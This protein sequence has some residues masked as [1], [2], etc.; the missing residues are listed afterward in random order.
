MIQQRGNALIACIGNFHDQ[1]GGSFCTS[2]SIKHKQYSFTHLTPAAVGSEERSAHNC[3]L[4]CHHMAHGSSCWG[5]KVATGD[6]RRQ[7]S[8]APF[9]QGCFSKGE[10]MQ[11]E[12]SWSYGNMLIPSG[13][14]CKETL[15]IEAASSC[16]LMQNNLDKKR[17]KPLRLHLIRGS[18]CPLNVMK[19]DLVMRFSWCVSVECV[20]WKRCWKKYF[21]IRWLSTLCW[22]VRNVCVFQLF[23]YFVIQSTN[24]WSVGRKIGECHSL[25]LFP[26]SPKTHKAPGLIFSFGFFTNLPKHTLQKQSWPLEVDFI[27]CF[28]KLLGWQNIGKD[29]MYSI[30]ATVFQLKL[31]P[32]SAFIPL[33]FSLWLAPSLT[34]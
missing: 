14:E 17:T 20:F 29:L 4:C 24:I 15:L 1:W 26:L 6:R 27:Y 9:N 3:F 33:T 28:L 2:E 18:S 13:S 31:W 30:S 25:L 16:L 22:T 34:F 21:H 11:L 7:E 19:R 32:D 12:P 10:V 5:V 8:G 23:G